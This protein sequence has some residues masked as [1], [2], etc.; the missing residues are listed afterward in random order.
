MFVR[1]CDRCGTDSTKLGDKNFLS[2]NVQ[3][4]NFSGTFDFCPKCWGEIGKDVVD[5]FTPDPTE[6]DAD[7]E[8]IE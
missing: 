8:K 6:S 1:V 3:F 4:K 5:Y 7:C 2:F